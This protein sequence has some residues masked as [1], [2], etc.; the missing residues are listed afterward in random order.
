[1]LTSLVTDYFVTCQIGKLQH[2]R[3]QTCQP[4][5]CFRGIFRVKKRDLPAESGTVGRAHIEIFL[6]VGLYR[7]CVPKY[8][9]ARRFGR[10]MV[11]YFC[12][13]SN[14]ITV[15]TFNWVICINVGAPRQRYKLRARKKKSDFVQK[16]G[17]FHDLAG[18]GTSGKKTGLSRQKR[19]GW[20]VCG[21]VVNLIRV[22]MLTIDPPVVDTVADE[23]GLNSDTDR[24]DGADRSGVLMAL[25]RANNICERVCYRRN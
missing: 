25:F 13:K 8:T 4:G 16:S 10:G 11:W 3:W 15:I 22:M 7:N 6:E 21:M 14:G 24:S 5:E 23:V 1:M 18:R 19:D 9:V 20:Q 17:H 2:G 12:E